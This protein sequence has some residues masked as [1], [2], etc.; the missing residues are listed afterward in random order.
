MAIIKDLIRF[1]TFFLCV[2]STVAEPVQY[3]KYGKRPNEDV[4]FCMGVTMHQ[5]ISTNSH[6]LVLSLMV[7]RPG[8]SAIGWTSIGLGPTMAGSLMFFIYG[9]PL[10]NENPIVSIRGSTGHVQPKLVTQADMGGADLRVVRSQWLP[11]AHGFTPDNPTYI[12]TVQL[13]CY[14]CSKWPGTPISAF[15]NSQPWIWAWNN[16]QDIQV[17]SHDV[18]L[19]MHTHHAGQGG[20]GT[21]YVDMARSVNTYP[22]APSFPPIRPK[23]EMLGTSDTASIMEWI[24]HNPTLHIHGVSMVLAFLVLFPAGVIAIR[25]GSP[26]S[27]KYHW[28]IQLV[29]SVLTTVGVMSGFLLERPINSVHQ[30]VGI[31]I[32]SCIGI[33]GVLGW[34]HHMDF[35]QIHQRTWISHSHI[36]LGR[37]MMV[38]GWTNLV[39]GMVLRGWR[40]LYVIIM[41]AA[42]C[43]EMVGLS[44]WIW[45]SVRRSA[46]ESTKD[47]PVWNTEE[48]AQ[49]YFA[50]A[51]AED[52]GEDSNDDVEKG[53]NEAMLEADDIGT[54][55]RLDG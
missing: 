15:S 28:V 55:M 42:V 49:K 7:P 9:D 43:T 47:R 45:L 44:V 34:R 30:G 37:V 17:Y 48:D 13:I 52:E 24:I 29:A 27:F 21:F 41:G 20:F 2:T 14:S 8:G 31:G 25:S 3:C 4:A 40:T 36:W 18:H 11:A 5:N 16:K 32:A 35:L 23:I 6:D 38:A 12:A 53:E 51:E 54:G 10:S 39:S 50:L 33:Q 22:N 26:K 46:K 19:V 1:T